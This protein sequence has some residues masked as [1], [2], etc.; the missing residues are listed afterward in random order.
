MKSSKYFNKHSLL[1]NKIQFYLL[2]ILYKESN[3][4]AGPK[5]VTPSLCNSYNKA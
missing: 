3:W 1:E 4:T 5:Y 2:H